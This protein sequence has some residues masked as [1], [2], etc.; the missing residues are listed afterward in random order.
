MNTNH[1]QYF[2]MLAKTKNF[3]SAAERC[4]T[5]QPNLSY[6]IRVLEE[7]LGVSLIDRSGRKTAL[8]GAAEL[9]LPYVSAALRELKLGEKV[10]Q[11]YMVNQDEKRSLRIGGRKLNFFSVIIGKTLLDEGYQDVPFEAFDY[12]FQKAQEL[13]LNDELEIAT[14]EWRPNEQCPELAYIPVKLPDMMLVV[15]EQHPLAE[16]D[17]VSLWQT[18]DYPMVSKSGHGCMVDE[19]DALF[20]K[21]GFTPNIVSYVA[22]QNVVLSLVESRVGIALVSDVRTVNAFRVKKIRIDWPKQDFY[23]C[24]CFRKN[25]ALSIPAQIICTRIINENGID[26]QKSLQLLHESVAGHAQ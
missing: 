12:S 9:Y 26:P 20:Q 7:E 8:T 16:F 23:Y 13:V 1:L 22:T 24:F 2:E 21:A 25:A 14:G 3:S 6:G 11:S 10:L 4:Y 15:D 17:S 18:K 19:I 5:T